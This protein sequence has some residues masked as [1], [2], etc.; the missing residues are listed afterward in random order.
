MIEAINPSYLFQYHRRPIEVS[1]LSCW[2]IQRILFHLC[3]SV[4]KIS[5]NKNPWKCYISYKNRCASESSKVSRNAKPFL[6][7]LLMSLQIYTQSP[8]ARNKILKTY[9]I[10]SLRICSF[11]KCQVK[12][13]WHLFTHQHLYP[14]IKKETDGPGLRFPPPLHIAYQTESFLSWILKKTQFSILKTFTAQLGYILHREDFN[15]FFSATRK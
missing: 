4:V 2:L 3:C 14:S 11:W 7:W 8:A 10:S 6:V 5:E 13:S 9:S 1:N 12:K 15:I